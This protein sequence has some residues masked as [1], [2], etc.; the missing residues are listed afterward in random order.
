MPS[1]PLAT[2]GIALQQAEQASTEARKSAAD[3]ER[4]ITALRDEVATLNAKCQKLQRELEDQKRLHQQDKASAVRAVEEEHRRQRTENEKDIASA[5]SALRNLKNRLSPSGTA[6]SSVNKTKNAG[7]VITQASPAR[8]IIR[9]RY[10]SPEESSIVPSKRPKVVLDSDSSDG[11][12]L[13]LPRKTEMAPQREASVQSVA[14]ISHTQFATDDLVSQNEPA[15][16]P[17]FSHSLSCSM[18]TRHRRRSYADSD[19]DNIVP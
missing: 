13:P 10:C 4:E 12:K 17:S 6:A 7:K 2:L 3:R 9:K 19:R 11:E 15:S 14:S 18:L 5:E 16:P 1:D 8:R